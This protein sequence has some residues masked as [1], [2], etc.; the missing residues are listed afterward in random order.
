M[1]LKATLEAP[2]T[3]EQKVEF[4]IEQN[5]NLGYE[6]RGEQPETLTAWGYTEEEKAEQR[7]ENFKSNFFEIRPVNDVFQGGW[8]RKKPKGY[9]SAVESMN[10]MFNVVSSIGILPQDTLIFYTAPDFTK[11]EECTEEWLIAHQFKNE[12]MTATQFGQFYVAF[13]Q[14][15]NT[16]EHE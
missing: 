15:W 1:E 16:E 14:A 5:H 6:I 12:E 11:E 8:Y 7:E 13:M 2:Y 3:E 9:S 4:I 10:S